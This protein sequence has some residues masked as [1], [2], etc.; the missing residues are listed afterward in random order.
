MAYSAA[1]A[2][3]HA[4]NATALRMRAYRRRRLAGG[5]FFRVRVD[6]VVALEEMLRAAGRSVHM[7]T[8]ALRLRPR[9]ASSLR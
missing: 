1:R 2:E 6:D 5:A 8:A 4:P 7:P 9:L 3:G